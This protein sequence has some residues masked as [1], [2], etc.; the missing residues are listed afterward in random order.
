[1]AGK[2][3]GRGHH[4]TSQWAAAD[5]IDA[6]KQLCSGPRH[7]FEFERRP[8]RHG[9]L[10]RFSRMRAALPLTARR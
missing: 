7:S 8:E 6:R 4:R 3:D 5:F 10:S 2:Y 1:M 9:Y